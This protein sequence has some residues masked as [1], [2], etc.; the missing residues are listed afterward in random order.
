MA[1]TGSV[2]RS[3]PVDQGLDFANSI[4]FLQAGRLQLYF[5]TW[6]FTNRT[7]V[8]IVVNLQITFAA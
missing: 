1:V 2:A 6:E 3:S 7:L 8:A 5:F 4:C